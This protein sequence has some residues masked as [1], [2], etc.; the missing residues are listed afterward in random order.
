MATD[1]IQRWR[2]KPSWYRN[3]ARD[4]GWWLGKV[5]RYGRRPSGRR[6]AKAIGDLLRRLSRG[7]AVDVEGFRRKHLAQILTFAGTHCPYYRALFQ[8][9]HFNLERF[10]SLRELPLLD[11]VAVKEHLVDLMPEHIAS[12]DIHIQATGGSTGVPLEFPVFY[13]AGEVERVHQRFLFELM[14]Y[15]P[16]DRIVALSGRAL[17]SSEVRAGVYWRE[18]LFDMPYPCLG[19]YGLYMN[20]ETLPRYAERLLSYDP[21]F[22]TG[23]PSLITDLANFLRMHHQRLPALKA[24]LLTSE[25]ISSWHIRQ[26]QEGLDCAVFLQYGHAELSVFAYTQDETYRYR[27]SP[28]YSHVEV[29][30]NDGDPVGAGEE[31]EIVVTGF[32]NRAFPLIRYRTGD[33][34]VYG[35]EERGIVYLERVLGRTEDEI[36]LSSHPWKVLPFHVAVFE[37]DYVALRNVWRWQIVQDVPGKVTLR[38]VRRPEYGPRDEER[39]R[40]TFQAAYDVEI[41]FEYVDSIPPSASGK[42]RFVIQNVHPPEHTC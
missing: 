13:L 26:I 29:L 41:D 24:V 17:P 10:E 25:T 27:C 3:L 5:A 14:G 32:Y 20:S 37:P 7:E 39:I 22:I 12:M 21:Q 18:R 30:D 42:H 9:C 35:G 34:A 15:E 2:R 28:F 11:K 1:L 6:R 40:E 16:G 8:S 19:L 23:Y 38:I 36:V 4:P 33:R 31:G